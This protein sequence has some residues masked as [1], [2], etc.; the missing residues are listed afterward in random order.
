VERKARAAWWVG[1]LVAAG[2]LAVGGAAMVWAMVVGLGVWGLNRTVGWAF[3]IS[4]FVYWIGIGHAGTMISA[5]LHLFRQRWRTSINRA[6]EGMTIFAV[7][8]A[9]I[10]PLVHM[11]RPWYLFWLAPYPNNR[12]PLWVNFRS[13]LL[14]D[15]FAILTYL[16]VSLVFWYV[17]M[18]PDLATLRDRATGR[19]QRALYGFFALGWNGSA[20]DWNATLAVSLAVQAWTSAVPRHDH[21]HHAGRGVHRCRRAVA[22]GAAVARPSRAGAARRDR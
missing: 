11:G 14:W 16:L 4:N 7:A 5:V 1:F 6:A 20:R 9:A 22:A 12:G 13:P 2:A 8:C 15:F 17:G 3:D 18:I 21:A 10:Y 19:W